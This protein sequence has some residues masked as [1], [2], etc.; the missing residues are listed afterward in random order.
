MWIPNNMGYW[1]DPWVWF[2]GKK[3]KIVLVKKGW[4]FLEFHFFREFQFMASTSNDN[5]LSSDQNT[6]QFLV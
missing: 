1:G 2:H 6:N 5:S 4:V 3:S